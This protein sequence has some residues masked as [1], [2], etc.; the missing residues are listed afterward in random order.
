MKQSQLLTEFY[1]AYSDWLEAGASAGNPFRVDKGLCNN[2]LEYVVHVKNMDMSEH[3]NI[4]AEMT[5]QFINAGLSSRYPFNNDNA[6][7]YSYE[8]FS[9]SCYKNQARIQWVKSHLLGE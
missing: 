9:D 4:S 5:A 2:L 7:S 8:V 6:G 1:R 3:Y